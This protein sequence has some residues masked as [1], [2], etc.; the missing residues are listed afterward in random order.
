MHGF[1]H[2][3]R[4]TVRFRDLDAMG[5]VNNAVYL[6]YLEQARLT[7]LQSLGLVRGAASPE[8]ILARVEVDFRDQIAPG[9][10]VEIGVRAARVGTKSFELEHRL[11][12]RGRH[13]ADARSVLVSYDYDRQESVPVPET[14][15]RALAPEG[16]PA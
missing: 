2:T 4:E 16:V 6:T 12:V 10:E 14:W 8:M 1:P 7:Y 13:V 5:H 3:H 15:R 11:E 9:D